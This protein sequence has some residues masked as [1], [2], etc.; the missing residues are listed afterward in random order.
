M[1]WF[2]ILGFIILVAMAIF[3]YTMPSDPAPKLKKKTKELKA[4]MAA[5]AAAKEASKDWKIIAERWEKQNNTLSAEV[6][7][8]KMHQQD[9][10]KQLGSH[11]GHEKDLLDKLSQ[12]KS[13][14][15]KEQVNLDK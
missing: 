4:Q 10:E 14:R 9:L 11:K 7:R 5:E 6:E 15:E 1:F 2:I 13:W 8:L 12:E 3:I